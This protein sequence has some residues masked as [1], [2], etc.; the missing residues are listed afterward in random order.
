[1]E[2]IFMK[3]LMENWKRYLAEGRLSPDDAQ[4]VADEVL[5]KVLKG[6]PFYPFPEEL[7]GDK[8]ETKIEE[9]K[10]FLRRQAAKSVTRAE[11]MWD[12]I[13]TF[14]SG[15]PTE[16][17]DVK[18]EQDA[19]QVLLQLALKGRTYEKW[20]EGKKQEKEKYYPEKRKPQQRQK[21]TKM[22]QR[23]VTP[24]PPELSGDTQVFIQKESIISENQDLSEKEKTALKAE[25]LLA[26]VMN[27]AHA[28]EISPYQQFDKEELEAQIN[29]H[30]HN[31]E[32]SGIT[33][34]DLFN[35]IKR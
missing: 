26:L 22:S 9:T 18:N 23:R 13:K 2:K 4:L 3:L 19:L 6:E 1:M 10:I 14:Q 5:S 30:N 24:E 20:L 25:A 28:K 35:F 8:E 21:T 31:G 32:F 29:R 27:A 17:G 34:Q 11:D 16:E 12:I 33:D 15:Y 7:E